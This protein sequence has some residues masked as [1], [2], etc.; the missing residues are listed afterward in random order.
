MLGDLNLND[1]SINNV[2]WPDYDDNAVNKKYADKL[3]S[4]IWDLFYRIGARNISG[5]LIGGSGQ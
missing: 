3:S 1:Y 4:N 2:K 5:N